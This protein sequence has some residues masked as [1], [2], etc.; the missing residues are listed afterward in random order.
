MCS[1]AIHLSTS[2]YKTKYKTKYYKWLKVGHQAANFVVMETQMCVTIP[3]LAD[4][5][6]NFTKWGTIL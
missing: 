3:V 2:Y 1:P 6:Y 4:Y 5:Q